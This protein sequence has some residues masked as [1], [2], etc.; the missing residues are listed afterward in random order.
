MM[1]E[2]LSCQG[3]VA[4]QVLLNLLLIALPKLIQQFDSDTVLLLCF[5]KLI[6]ELS[7]TWQKHNIW[8]RPESV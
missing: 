8:T 4:W 2:S 7:S 3:L 6:R 5:V 1:F